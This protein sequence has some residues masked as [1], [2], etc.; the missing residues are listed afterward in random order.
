MDVPK[1]LLKPEKVKQ[2]FISD[3]NETIGRE[4]SHRQVHFKHNKDGQKK[5]GTDLQNPST[6]S[7]TNLGKGEKGANKERQNH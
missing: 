5:G 7:Q 2:S 3:A 4:N 1:A 6:R